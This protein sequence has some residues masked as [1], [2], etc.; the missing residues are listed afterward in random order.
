MRLEASIRIEST[1]KLIVAKQIELVTLIAVGEAIVKPRIRE[2]KPA[3]GKWI[4][5]VRVNVKIF[6][7]HVVP[8]Q[9]EA[10]AKAFFH[11]DRESAVERFSRARGHKHVAKLRGKGAFRND[12]VALR[13]IE[14]IVHVVE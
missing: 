9:L 10:L 6:R 2:I 4:A 12:N 14:S 5:L 8:L 13:V 11:S 1:G 7:Q 3:V